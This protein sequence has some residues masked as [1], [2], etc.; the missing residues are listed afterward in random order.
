[1]Y[2]GYVVMDRIEVRVDRITSVY[3]LEEGDCDG[4]QYDVGQ[5]TRRVA[6]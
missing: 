3:L 5:V 2:G 1:M 4:S 6:A